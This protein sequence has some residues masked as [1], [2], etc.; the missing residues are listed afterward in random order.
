MSGSRLFQGLLPLVVG[1]VIGAYG[2]VVR[3]RLLHWGAT[4]DEVGRA[5][6]GDA[7]V[8]YP[9]TQTTMAVTLPAPPEE[10]WP[11]LQQMGC[12]RAGWYSWDRLDNGGRPSAERIV[13]EWQDMKVGQRIDA[14]PG[15]SAW[16]TA[17][18]V[19]PPQTLVL[20]SDLTVPYGRPFDPERWPLPRLY[21]SG[22]WGFHLKAAGDGETRLV[23]RTRSRG[24]P[25]PL[26]WASDFL[27][28]QPAH[29]VMQTRQF[30]NLRARAGPSGSARASRSAPN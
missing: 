12:N 2:A 7:L 14:V 19:E 20:R 17:A 26:L 15:G 8:P 28:G 27:F 29:F 23:V 21:A 5:F 30:Q 18:V 10:V 4:D 11:W 25:R 22:V 24:R 13:P 16:F 1:T 9:D 6:P 3:P